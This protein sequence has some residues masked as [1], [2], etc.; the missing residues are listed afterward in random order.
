[1]IYGKAFVNEWQDPSSCD[2][3]A[4]EGI[5]L[6]VATNSELQVTGGDAFDAQVLGRVPSELEH[7]C[8][9]ILENGGRVHGCFR[10]DTYIVLR[11]L[12]EV[13]V[14]TSYGELQSCFLASRVHGF[15][16][17]WFRFPTDGFLRRH[18]A[19]L[20]KK[21]YASKGSKVVSTDPVAAAQCEEGIENFHECHA[22]YPSGCSPSGRYDGY[23][24]YL[25]NQN[26][27]RDSKPAL[28]F[29]SLNDYHDL[30]SRTPK[31]LGKSNHADLK[32]Q[33]PAM[34]EG[35]PAAVIGYLYYV[36]Q[37]GAESS[38]CELTAPDDTDYHIGIGFDKDTA[39]RL[40]DHPELVKNKKSIPKPLQQASVIVEMTPHFR[41]HFENDIWT[42]DNLQKA[43][44]RQVR[45][46]GQL[47]LDSEHYTS[48]QDCA[49][50]GTSSDRKSCWRASAWELHPVERFQVCN[51]STNDCGREES[52]DWIEL[53]SL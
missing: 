20:T 19:G 44:G 17:R 39:K 33:L 16:L 8:G 24:N 6:F 36:K 42:V 32:D 53:D 5:E 1:L 26:P 34:G 9:K 30:E 49:I 35:H 37:E 38:N 27:P 13:A 29:T 43:I 47:I 3:R 10:A 28:V 2:C 11:A 50:A 51:K 40:R 23:L 22:S 14:D 48:G 46:V 45:V 18:R 4:H 25:K 41:F 21:R 31:E 15:G 12:F 7:L 52:T